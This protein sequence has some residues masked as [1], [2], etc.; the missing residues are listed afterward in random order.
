MIKAAYERIARQTR[1]AS[2]EAW[3]P[4]SRMSEDELRLL[5]QHRQKRYT[6]NRIARASRKRNLRG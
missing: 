1:Q 4:T 6:K 3:N 2:R 5:I